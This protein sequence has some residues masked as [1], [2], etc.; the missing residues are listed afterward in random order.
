MVTGTGRSLSCQRL[1][2]KEK[3][4]L[5]RQK[6]PPR[7][8]LPGVKSSGLRGKNRENLREESQRFLSAWVKIKMLKEKDGYCSGEFKGTLE[9]EKKGQEVCG[10]KASR[11][12]KR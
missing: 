9:N 8:P 7:N 10:K 4:G 2:L 12:E 11:E 3:G 6:D 5:E 1:L